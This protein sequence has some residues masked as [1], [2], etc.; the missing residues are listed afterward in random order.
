MK[1]LEDIPKKHPFNV[2][3]GYFDR[4]PGIIQSR[5]AEKSAQPQPTP[6]LRYAL[7][8]AIPM[9]LIAIA[10]IFYF[11]PE[12]AR[13]VD[14]ILASVSTEELVAYLEESDISTDELLETVEFD[15]ES[16]EAIEAESYLNYE[17]GDDFSEMNLELE[18]L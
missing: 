6:Y 10:A 8:Y 7:Q 4:L 15:T 12:P 2:P 17:L 9:V 1:N 16:V 14:T 13:D 5:I 3:D 18:N 11:T